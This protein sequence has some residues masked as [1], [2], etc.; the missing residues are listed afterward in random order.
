MREK[1]DVKSWTL[2]RIA[3]KCENPRRYDY[4]AL[5]SSYGSGID[6]MKIDKSFRDGESVEWEGYKIQ[7]DWMPGQTEFGCCLWLDIDGQRIAFTGDNL[8]ANSADE[9][10]N[11]HEAVVAR[12]SSIFEEGYLLG[13]RY[14][15]D[16]KPDLVMGS[17]SYVMPSPEG[18]LNRYHEWSKEI[19]RLYNDLLPGTDYEYLYDPYWVS[20]FPYRVDLSAKDTHIIQVTV[21]NVRS[22]PQRHRVELKLPPGIFAEP[23]ILEGTVKPESRSSFPV[24]L[25]VDR[26]LA[27]PSLQIV[28]FDIILD[29]RHH[30]ELFDFTIR[31]SD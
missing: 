22:T 8:F 29:G 10:Q 6:G 30:G 16:L 25:T 24:K 9:S 3:D 23:T 18:M 26:M 27:S 4:A 14:L 20:A 12:N 5:V 11:G 28:P 1:Y 21:R 2:D 7:V 17:H 15:K 13:S 19:I 31:T